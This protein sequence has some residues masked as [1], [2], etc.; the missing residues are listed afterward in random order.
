VFI[1]WLVVQVFGL[2]GLPIAA[3]VLRS[4]PDRGYAFAKAL[5][6]LLTGYGAWLLAMLGFG[7]F[8]TLLL[9]L[10]ML[11]LGALGAW[12][13]HAQWGVTLRPG[14]LAAHLRGLLA[15]HWRSIVFYELLFAALLVG[16]VW[17]RAHSVGFVGPHPWGTERPM[18]FAF[19]NAIR[20][21]ASFPPVDPWLAGYSINY[22]YFGYLLMAVLATFSGLEPATA[23][24]L[25]LAVIFALT[26]LGVAGIILNLVQLTRQRLASVEQA[27]PGYGGYLAA[28]LGVLLVLL[29]GNQAGALQVIVGDQRVV[30]LDARQLN[31]AVAQAIAQ[32]EGEPIHLPYPARTSDFDTFTT[33]E[34]TDRVEDF[35]W[36]W[37]SRALWDAYADPTHAEPYP[38]RRYNITEFPFFSFWLGDMHP[39]VMA[40]PFNLLMLALVLATLARPELPQFAVGGRGWLELLLTGALL[41]SLYVINSWDLPTYALLYS[42]ALLL[43]GVRLAGGLAGVR[44]WVLARTLLLTVLAAYLLFAPFHL[45]FRSLVG[46]A[47]P[48]IDLPLVGGLSTI[49]APYTASRSGL[50]AFLIIFGLF[51][52]PLLALVYLSP[53]LRAAPQSAP[54]DNNEATD[55]DDAPAAAP[56]A[57][58]FAALAALLPWLPPLLLLLGLLVGFPLLALAGLG[59]LAAWRA[60]RS[61][62]APDTPAPAESFA[63]LVVALGCAICF[64][65]ELIYIRDVFNNRMNTIFKFYY[66]VWLLWGTLA[67]FA[68]WWLSAW[69]GSAQAVPRLLRRLTLASVQIVF[70]L[71]LAGGLVYP[72]LN[73]RMVLTE[74]SWEG[75]AGLTPRERTPEGEAAIEWLRSNTPRGSVILEAVGPSYNGEGYAAISASTGRPT[76][77]GWAGHQIQWRGGDSAARAELTPREDE[78]ELIYSTGDEAQALDLLD[79]YNVRYVYVGQ[80]ERQRYDAASLEKFA[81]IAE[82]VFEEGQ[83]TI[84]RVPWP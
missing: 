45:T 63:L 30:A 23:Y 47:E 76:V 58:S 52:L 40:L 64:G 68:L 65:T 6:L 28:L 22:Y 57:S 31:T 59:L 17:M 21:S 78:I 10:V 69:A 67:A 13:L 84:Y 43:L 33:L 79:K 18:D 35:D 44:W 3:F 46:F 70:V 48:L 61:A 39:H 2:L 32:Q 49:I 25:S 38:L 75:L 56:P 14:P 20:Y 82:P 9:L 50:H 55:D 12:L 72:A 15:Q 51:V 37:P 7:S 16:L 83:V 29:V 26:G 42:G 80:L 41:G 74:G 4:L 24:N 19:F 54:G 73:L 62:A 81:R 5:G 27:R 34:P 1:W 60:V 66:Q 71:L 36:W 77:L 8:G 11:G 53:T